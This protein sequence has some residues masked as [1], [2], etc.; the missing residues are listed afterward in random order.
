MG[1]SAQCLDYAER[2]IALS[3]QFGMTEERT[4]TLQFRGAAR[5]ELGDSVG[6]IVDLR[7]A[8]RISREHGFSDTP[9]AYVNLG[10]ALWEY[11]GPAEALREYTNA[12]EFAEPR[13]IRGTA[14]WAMAQTTWVLF[15]LG[16]WD[17]LLEV[18]DEVVRRDAW[19]SQASVLPIPFRLRVLALRGRLE[20]A[21]AE[22]PDLLERARHI[23]DPQVLVPALTAAA[24][25]EDQLGRS[26]EAIALMAEIEG[27]DLPA[28]GPDFLFEGIR[29]LVRGG[30]VDRARALTDRIVIQMGPRIDG[31]KESF[32]AAIAEGDGDHALALEHHLRASEVWETYEFV[33]ERGHAFLGTGR[34]LIALGRPGEA[35][36][37]LR[38]ARDIL[39]GL[40]GVRLVDEADRMLA[41]AT[42]LSS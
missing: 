12:I 26:A 30:A 25:V 4:R 34:S 7:E 18:V 24:F 2:T 17:R 29:V 37:P 35:V 36:G 16:E 8:V 31:L 3:E 1:A 13:G 41:E 6:G 11:V 33:L 28:W 39:A 10:D 27:R 19:A 32:R 40:G 9:S 14:V 21:A 20:E 42:A 22:V 5:Q 23:G 38:T 15:D